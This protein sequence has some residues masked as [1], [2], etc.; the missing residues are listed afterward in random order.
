MSSKSKF[1]SININHLQFQ[2][3]ILNRR[4]QYVIQG[5]D[6]RQNHPS[7]SKLIQ[8]QPFYLR[9]LELGIS[10]IFLTIILLSCGIT[11]PDDI[12]EKLGFIALFLWVNSVFKNNVS[13]TGLKY[14]TTSQNHCCIDPR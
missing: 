1:M 12:L 3:R 10:I 13:T 9:E 5:G 14:E 7:L 11:P 6:H 8:D 2:Y 4:I